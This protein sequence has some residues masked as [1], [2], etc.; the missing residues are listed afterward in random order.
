VSVLRAMESQYEWNPFTF[1]DGLSGKEIPRPMAKNPMYRERK[2]A[3]GNIIP[4][5]KLSERIEFVD[6]YWSPFENRNS[7]VQVRYFFSVFTTD[8]GYGIKTVPSASITIVRQKVRSKAE[9]M[10]GVDA[11]MATGFVA[12]KTDEEP[13]VGSKRAADDD[14]D[15]S[16][17]KR[18]KHAEPTPGPPGP[19]TDEELA[20]MME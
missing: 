6:P 1:V 9:A 17:A 15:E 12:A 14:D 16:S 13:E 10:Y 7:L 11:S 3:S 5:E 2:D 4:A 20:L 18:P 8:T 19:P